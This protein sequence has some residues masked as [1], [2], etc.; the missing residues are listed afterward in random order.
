[1]ELSTAWHFAAALGLGMLIGLERERTRDEQMS[2]AGVRTFPLVSLLGAT[3][4]YAGEQ[5]GLPWLVGLVFL[6]IV[7]VVVVAYH[8]TARTGDIGA[9]TEVSVFVTFFIGSSC[10]NDRHCRDLQYYG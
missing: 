5:S 10:P 9:T 3:A 8:L 4:V 2:F 1:M 6:G 7:A